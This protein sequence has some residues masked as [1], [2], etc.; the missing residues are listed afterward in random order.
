MSYKTTV[1]ENF[2]L[3]DFKNVAAGAAVLGSGGGGSYTDAVQLLD[4]LGPLSISV[5]VQVYKGGVNACV[6]AM[7][8]SPDVG[9][10]LALT[11]LQ[12]AITNTLKAYTQATGQGVTCAVPA[13]HVAQQSH[14]GSERVGAEENEGE[15][16]LRVNADHHEEAEWAA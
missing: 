1:P 10:K 15:G 8:G 5:P 4:Q 9:E 12:A 14:G 6:L 2:T 7:M 13:G 16:D 11:D 3:A